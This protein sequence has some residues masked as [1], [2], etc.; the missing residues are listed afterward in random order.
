MPA[1]VLAS[2]PMAFTLAAATLTSRV[3]MSW[4][5]ITTDPPVGVGLALELGLA[6]C[7]GLAEAESVGEADGVG[8]GRLE[9]TINATTR[10]IAVMESKMMIAIQGQTVGGF[11]F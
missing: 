4:V 8:D 9:P 6:L 1:T 5:V 2:K 3:M 11:G 7:D 10:L